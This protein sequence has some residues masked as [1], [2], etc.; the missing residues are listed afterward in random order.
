M[1]SRSMPEQPIA[2]HN[3]SPHAACHRS[4]PEN[5]R[6]PVCGMLVDPATA[7]HKTSH[8]GQ[9]FFFCSAGCLAKFTADP[10]RYLEPVKP[11]APMAPGGAIYTCPMHPQI[12]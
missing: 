10:A 6:D 3:Q 4:A 11:V 8:G 9:A 7:K 12:R 5:A 2:H 1:W